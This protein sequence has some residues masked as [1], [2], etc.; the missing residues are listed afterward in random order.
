MGLYLL[1]ETSID[2]IKLVV[3]KWVR[4]FV[5]FCDTFISLQTH[6]ILPDG[7]AVCSA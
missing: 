5:K 7:N 3:G 6:C 4:F 1:K 2:C